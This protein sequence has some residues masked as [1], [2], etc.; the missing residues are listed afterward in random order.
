MKKDKKW[1]ITSKSDFGK[2]SHK[3]EDILTTILKNRDLTAKKDIDAFLHPD[4]AQVTTDLVDLSK[5][6]LTTT[7]QRIKKALDEKE[8]IVVFGDY[9]VDGI[10]GTAILWETLH[11]MG[12]SVTPYIPSRIEEGYGLSIAGIENVLREHPKTKLIITVDNGIVANTAVDLA[13]A[14]GIEV[15]VTDHHVMGEVLPKALSIFHTTKL[16]GTGVAWMLSQQL[17]QLFPNIQFPTD[18][19]ALVALA[20]VAD[21]VPLTHANRIVLSRGLDVL[22]TTKRPGIK[23]I[24]EEAGINQKEIGVYEIGHIVGPRLNAMGRIASAMDALR[25]LCTKD[26]M[27][28]KA[29]AEKLGMTNKERQEITKSLSTHATELAKEKTEKLL[30]IAQENYEEGIIGLV[31]GRLVE[32]YYRPSIVVSLGEKISK[33]SARSIA[34]FNIIEFIRSASHLLI[35]AGGHPMAAGF[36]VATE[37]VAE[38]EIF[39]TEQ[40]QHVLPD[41]LL[42]RMVR[43][44]CELPLQYISQKLYDILQ[45][46]QPFGMGNPEPTFVAKVTIVSFRLV[47]KDKNHVSLLLAPSSASKITFSAIAFNAADMFQKINTGQEGEVVYTIDENVWKD[48]KT[49]QLKIK[50]IRI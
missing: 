25:L 35:N 24:C 20:T 19:L 31:A 48:K 21:L 46:L 27:R 30:F 13:V 45:Q 2:S 7:I 4:I 40:V 37:K 15:I 5:D 11:V 28:A 36:T 14:K 38:L 18:H 39:L 49:L 33:A 43:I 17:Q 3:E 12:A 23:A 6:Q 47:G 1:E 26:G 50:D 9:D 44:D 10:C 22:H 41:E 42:S 32:T 34:G 29:L 8:E 16:C